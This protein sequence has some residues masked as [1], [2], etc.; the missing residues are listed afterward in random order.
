MRFL[1]NLPTYSLFHSVGYKN[2]S[3]GYIS[4]TVKYKYHTVK[5]NL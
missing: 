2:H 4:H 1:W 3:V 5:Q